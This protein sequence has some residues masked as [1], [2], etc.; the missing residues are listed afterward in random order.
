MDNIYT[1]ILLVLFC[2]YF[3]VFEVIGIATGNIAVYISDYWNLIDQ[4]Y[5]V[6]FVV[7]IFIECQTDR[8]LIILAIVNF[9]S[10][11]RGLSYFRSFKRFRILIYLV[12]QVI[13]ELIPF[14]SLMIISIL[15]FSTT[16]YTLR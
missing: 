1:K 2:I 10:W 16:F 12:Q 15:G 5:I 6:L 14:I 13:T 7:W 4:F 9:L 8:H 3:T 11:F